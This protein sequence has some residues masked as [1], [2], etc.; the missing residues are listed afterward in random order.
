MKHVLV[1]FGT[2][3]EGIK[4]MPVVKA[5]RRETSFKTTVAVT[6]QHRQMLD[7]VFAVFG[8]KPDIDLNLMAPSQT[9][10]AITANVVLRMSEVL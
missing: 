10:A 1:V 6:G 4:M 3:P 7:Q 2:R 5:A 9:L 8:E